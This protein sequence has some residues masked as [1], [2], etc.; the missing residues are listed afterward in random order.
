M[1][2]FINVA[3]RALKDIH[4]SIVLFGHALFGLI[5]AISYFV[6]KRIVSGEPFEFFTARQYGMLM[7]PC[8]FE[9]LLLYANLIAF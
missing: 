2:A 1:I 6:I 9:F 4:Y 3:N 5:L 8:V 7:I